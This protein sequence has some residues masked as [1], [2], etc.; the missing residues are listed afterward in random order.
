MSG[1]NATPQ[2]HKSSHRAADFKK[3]NVF[4]FSPH[5]IL[6]VH[7]EVGDVH[8]GERHGDYFP[9]LTFSFLSSLPLSFS[10]SALAAGCGE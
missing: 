7:L 9:S 6:G 10:S 4:F 2:P 8:G 1:L 5:F 3:I